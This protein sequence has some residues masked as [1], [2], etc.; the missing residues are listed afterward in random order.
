MSV[1]EAR[2]RFEIEAGS[3]GIPVKALAP[4]RPIPP[5]PRQVKE[6]WGP[7]D[8][9]SPPRSHINNG[10]SKPSNNVVSIHASPR[11]PRHQES[12]SPALPRMPLS[13]R[14][15]PSPVRPFNSSSPLFSSPHRVQASP[16]R[17]L[18][19]Q[20]GNSRLKPSLSPLTTRSASPSSHSSRPLISP[21]FGSVHSPDFSLLE[22]C[23]KVRPSPVKRP[24]LMPRPPPAKPPPRKPLCKPPPLPPQRQSSHQQLSHASELKAHQVPNMQVQKLL[25]PPE[26]RKALAASPKRFSPESKHNLL[27]PP[28]DLRKSFFIP[29]PK[30][31]SPELK[32]SQDASPKR[33]KASPSPLLKHKPLSEKEYGFSHERQ[34][35]AVDKLAQVKVDFVP[36][37]K[38]LFSPPVSSSN[39]SAGQMYDELK[40]G[41]L[42]KLAKE[43][44]DRMEVMAVLSVQAEERRAIE[45]ANLFERHVPVEGVLVVVPRGKLKGIKPAKKRLFSLHLQTR[46]LNY[47][48]DET[49]RQR[50]AAAKIFEHV[51]GGEASPNQAATFC[52]RFANQPALEVRAASQRDALRWLDALDLLRTQ[53]SPSKAHRKSSSSSRS[54][55]SS[56]SSEKRGSVERLDKYDDPETRQQQEAIRGAFRDALRFQV[57]SSGNKPKAAPRTP[58][59]NG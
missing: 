53:S 6:N 34:I 22:A 33:T 56:F 45:K 55:G 46:T 18:T 41:Y 23:E 51:T 27:S 16:N 52:I 10:L 38:A 15:V 47:W 48:K 37:E 19:P 50:G 44:E 49:L 5:P 25:S 8:I 32:Y 57:I 30:R 42:K 21:P 39:K 4:V 31:S 2:A 40:E 26:I 43:R 29:S 3:R 13:P 9:R 17:K 59:F 11:P 58:V 12:S 1:R 36:R 7:A 24:D 28:P 35:S 54:G 20:K 14:V